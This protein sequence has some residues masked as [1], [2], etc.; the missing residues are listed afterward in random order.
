MRDI[1][2]LNHGNSLPQLPIFFQAL[3]CVG[4]GVILLDYLTL[5]DVSISG[6]RN[7]E[8]D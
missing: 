4:E 6:G 7:V 3:I 1:P 8:G 5:R 2:H